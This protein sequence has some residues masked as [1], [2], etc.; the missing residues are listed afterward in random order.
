MTHGLISN[1]SYITDSTSVMENKSNANTNV[2]DRRPDIV[3]AYA[4][5]IGHM[6]GSEQ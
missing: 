2:T 5:V 1:P 6:L 3:F 4:N